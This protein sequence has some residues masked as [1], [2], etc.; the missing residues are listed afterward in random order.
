MP[1][2]S[3]IVTLP[4]LATAVT[5]AETIVGPAELKRV[6]KDES[7]QEYLD[8]NVQLYG[9]VRRATFF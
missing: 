1:H 9:T 2:V 8:A 3:E 5:R 7:L 6:I 4:P